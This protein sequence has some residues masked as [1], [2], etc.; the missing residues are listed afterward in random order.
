[1]IPPPT[2]TTTTVTTQPLDEV[3]RTYIDNVVSIFA[4]A[5]GR[6]VVAALISGA[7]SKA[8]QSFGHDAHV[9][10]LVV[11]VVVPLLHVVAALE[12]DGIFGNVRII[13]IVIIVFVQKTRFL[14][15]VN[16]DSVSLL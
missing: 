4:R 2:T 10:R 6:F 8:R 1:M 7:Q 5:S 15:A 9:T 14:I 16:V 11:V 12:F 3:R 13:G